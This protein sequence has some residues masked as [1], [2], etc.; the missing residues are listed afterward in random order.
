MKPDLT[1][2]NLGSVAKGAALE[3]FEKAVADIVRNIADTDPEKFIIALQAGFYTTEELLYVKRVASGLN[4]I[5]GEIGT[6]DDGFSQ[7]VTTK[8]GEIKTRENDIKPTVKLIPRRTFDEAAP[9]ESEF[10]LRL[11]AAPLGIAL[12]SVDGTKW[13]GQCMQSIKIWLQQA[14]GSAVPVLA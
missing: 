3:L 6:Q 1:P 2:V 5:V 10:L 12:F 7:K 8:Q 4:V 13:Q 9:V 11:K 14:L